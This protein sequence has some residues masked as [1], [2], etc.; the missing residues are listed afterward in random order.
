MGRIH[1]GMYTWKLNRLIEYTWIL[2]SCKIMM[3]L[4]VRP[5]IIFPVQK[6]LFQFATS[7]CF[8]GGDGGGIGGRGNSIGLP[9]GLQ[10]LGR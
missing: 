8:D 4:L 2:D 9:G 5:C 10:G 3:V 6:V 1:N 7:R